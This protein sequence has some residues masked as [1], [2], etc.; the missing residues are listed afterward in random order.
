MVQRAFD[1]VFNDRDRQAEDG[2]VIYCEAC[3]WGAVR[4]GIPVEEYEPFVAHVD[5]SCY[6]CE[7]IIDSGEVCYK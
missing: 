2:R 3:F 7:C 1:V 6:N 5:L 4:Y